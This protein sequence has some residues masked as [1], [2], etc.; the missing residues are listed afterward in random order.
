MGGNGI[1]TGVVPRCRWIH[2]RCEVT[3]AVDS[4]KIKAKDGSCFPRN[5][6][7]EAGN[8]NC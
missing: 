2:I 5:D 4:E 7:V 1:L 3:V 8:V 6:E